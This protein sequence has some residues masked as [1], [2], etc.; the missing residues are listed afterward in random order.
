MC[1]VVCGMMTNYDDNSC[2]N[3]RLLPFFYL[4]DVAKMY[5]LV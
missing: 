5:F 1:D 2:L 3:V 4:I